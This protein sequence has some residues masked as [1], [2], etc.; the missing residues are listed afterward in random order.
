MSAMKNFILTWLP[1]A[2]CGDEEA[3]LRLLTVGTTPN[4]KCVPEMVMTA[5]EYR[6]KGWSI[7]P[8]LP[9]AKQPCVKWKEFQ[10]RLPTVD[11]MFG[12]WTR[13]PEAGIALVLG[14]VS[15]VLVVDV[16]GEDAYR[17]LVGHLGDV[18]KTPKVLSGSGKPY[19]FH[20]F[21]ADPK[22]ETNAKFCPWCPTLEFRGKGGIVVLPPSVH[23]SG[24]RYRWA[25]GAEIDEI[26]L[27]EVPAPI[28]RE[29]RAR[30]RRRTCHPSSTPM[31]ATSSTSPRPG[32]ARQVLNFDRLASETQKFLYSVYANG[33]DWNCRLFRAAC[34]LA[35]NGI[36]KEM[37]TSLLLAG[38]RPWNNEET[39]HALATIESAYSQHRYPAERRHRLARRA[40][41]RNR[42]RG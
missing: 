23:R 7:V 41:A 21:F 31:A 33:G 11:E 8:Q 18:P 27:P 5:A 14:P 12:W 1:D 25:D 2:Q 37:A 36:A 28:L 42:R 4:F 22:I 10:I 15:D 24:R 29:L 16:D 13:W 3:R 39:Q 17:A 40:G 38:A 30:N 32:L 20:L 9:G 34:D 26:E 35:G 6:L 19:R